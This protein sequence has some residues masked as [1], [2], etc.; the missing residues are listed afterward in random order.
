MQ[1]KFSS[2]TRSNKET[3]RRLSCHRNKIW[4]SQRISTSHFHSSTLRSSE[5]VWWD[6]RLHFCSYLL[7]LP[8]T[9]SLFTKNISIF[10]FDISFYQIFWVSRLP[11]SWFSFR[12][13]HKNH[14]TIFEWIPA[15]TWFL[16]LR[17]PW[18][19]E[20][21]IVMLNAF[22]STLR[23]LPANDEI[24]LVYSSTLQRF[25]ILNFP[26]KNTLCPPKSNSN[27]QET[28]HLLLH[29]RKYLRLK[30]IKKEKN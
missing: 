25:S 28:K 20:D 3:F 23:F 18:F 16:S 10:I 6:F 19:V 14:A 27:Q 1:V 29:Q 4:L 15:K 13:M 12:D 21:L 22:T 26:L 17:F 9:S 8:P 2:T 30:R 7:R 24:L 5:S 11:M